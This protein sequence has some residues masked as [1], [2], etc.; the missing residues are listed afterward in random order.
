MAERHYTVEQANAALDWVGER[1]A[2]LRSAR[3]GLNDEEA[4]AALTEAG[5]TNGGGQPGR[6]VSD[7]FVE[8]R[9]ALVELQSMEVVLRDLDRGLVDF[10]SIRDGEEIFLCWEEGEDEIG[11]WH[12]LDAGYGGRRAL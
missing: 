1:I 8:M 6:I 12:E 5:P 3:E 4:R 7:A 2:R 10:P 11:Y 9:T